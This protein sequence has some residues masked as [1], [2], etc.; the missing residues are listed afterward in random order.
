MSSDQT[1]DWRREGRVLR[2]GDRVYITL[3]GVEHGMSEAD[4]RALIR[5]L[6]WCVTGKEVVFRDDDDRVC[7]MSRIEGAI[8]EG[9]AALAR[10]RQEMANV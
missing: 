3:G 2:Q 6:A 5:G 4:A 10:I 9:E 8:Q 7:A 1:T